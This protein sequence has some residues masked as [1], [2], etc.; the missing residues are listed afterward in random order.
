MADAVSMATPF[1]GF[2]FEWLRRFWVSMA[3]P[4]QVSRLMG[5]ARFKA[6]AVSMAAPFEGL[7]VQGGLKG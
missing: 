3:S 4:F 7:T 6:D 1:E 5:Y 2:M